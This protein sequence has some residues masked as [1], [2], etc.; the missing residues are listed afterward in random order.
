MF[1]RP[2]IALGSVINV[3]LEPFVRSRAERIIHLLCSHPK[4]KDV[5][6]YSVIAN[7]ALIGESKLDHFDTGTMFISCR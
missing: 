3:F 4:E 5:I 6:K 2:F 7:N 1:T